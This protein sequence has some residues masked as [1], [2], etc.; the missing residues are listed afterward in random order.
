MM[1]FI[2]CF[3]EF[4]LIFKNEAFDLSQIIRSYAP[5]A[6]EKNGRLQPE[7]AASVGCPDMDMG[8]LTSLVGVEV[9]TERSDAQNCRHG[10][11]IPHAT[12]QGNFF[13]NVE[14]NTHE[15]EETTTRGQ[16][17]KGGRPREGAGAQRRRLANE[18]MQATLWENRER[19]DK[20][21]REP[22][23]SGDSPPA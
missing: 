10:D 14:R 19:M 11:I 6:C 16:A 3:S 12:L 13:A 21:R 8:R 15:N 5:V 20:N 22:E 1:A 7:F 9:K 17:R 23:R 18:A 2:I 4:L